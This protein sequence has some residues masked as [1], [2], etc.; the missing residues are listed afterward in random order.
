MHLGLFKPTF[1]LFKLTNFMIAFSIKQ[2]KRVKVL[3]SIL[4]SSQSVVLQS[5]APENTANADTWVYATAIID[6]VVWKE[7]LQ[8]L[9]GWRGG[10]SR[11]LAG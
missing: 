5:F 11:K 7:I 3:R 10:R 1:N 4:F 8:Q 9:E 2:Q 6:R